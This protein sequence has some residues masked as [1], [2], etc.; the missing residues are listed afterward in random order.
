MGISAGFSLTDDASCADDLC[1]RDN[2]A[3]VRYNYRLRP[4]AEAMARLE[5]EW[6][7]ARWVWN[8]CVELGNA[9]YVARMAGEECEHPTWCR[10]AKKLTGWR[11]EFKWLREGSGKVQ[12]QVIRKWSVAYQQA[13][14]QPGKGFPKFKSSKRTPPS[15][16]YTASVFR[17]KSGKLSLVGGISI[18]VVWSRYLPSDAKSCVIFQDVEKHW[19]VSFVV[20]RYNKLFPPSDAAIGIDWGVGEV[21]TTTSPEFNLP[22]GSQINTSKKEINMAREKTAR[23]KPGSKSFLM[24]KHRIS[25]IRAAM[26]RRRRD[27]AFKWANRIVVNFGRI[28]IEDIRPSFLHESMMASRATDGAVGITKQILINMARAAKRAV[29]LVDPSYTTMTCASCGTRATSR[30]ALQVR[31]FACQSCGHTAGR[32]ENAARVIRA[33]AGFNPTNVDDVRPLHGMGCAAAI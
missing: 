22:G 15:L 13:L 26:A 23:A 19:N 14:S 10:M 11:A 1:V 32:D 3:I 7:C 18:P 20:R 25:C 33:R 27:R 8:Q 2:Q 21:A 12:A 4:G 9:A 31:T 30:I 16:E 24:S 6:N 5:Q 28:A 29:V 17:L